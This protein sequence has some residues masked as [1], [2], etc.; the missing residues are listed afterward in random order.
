MIIKKL[1]YM[2]LLQA[3]LLLYVAPSF[4][5]TADNVKCEKCVDKS[6]I[7]KKAVTASK[8]KPQAVSTTKIRDG[9]VTPEKLS[10][11]VRYGLTAT[12]RM[13]YS[14]FNEIQSGASEVVTASCYGGEVLTGGGCDCQ[15]NYTYNSDTTNYGFVN[16]CIPAGNSMIGGCLV[17]AANID[18]SK[19]GPPVTAYAI[20]VTEILSTND[21]AEAQALL[22]QSESSL[23]YVSEGGVPDL[24]AQFMIEKVRSAHAYHEEQIMLQLA[25]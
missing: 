12:I 23:P 22:S 16:A 20:C 25:Q 19:W 3:S 13:S 7:A 1:L 6:D 2:V 5:V 9:A 24:T 15:G 14:S 21:Q 17:G 10:E 18:V 11:R 4:A 8:I